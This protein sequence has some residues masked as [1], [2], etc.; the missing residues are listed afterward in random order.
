MGRVS[1][2]ELGSVV[3][4]IGQDNADVDT[5]G[6]DAS[7]KTTDGCGCDFGNVD[8]AYNTGL[9]NTETSNEA[10]SI[11]GAKASAVAHEDGNADDP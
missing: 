10:S 8:G 9:A 4:K 7:A 6:E 1:Q 3:G 2:I 11:H 5:A